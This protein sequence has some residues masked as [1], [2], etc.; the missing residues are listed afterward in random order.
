M[1]GEN[2]GARSGDFVEGWV[3]GAVARATRVF[4]G[5]ICQMF[6]QDVFDGAGA[7]TALHTAAKSAVDLMRG[8]RVRSSSRRQ[9]PYVAIA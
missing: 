1:S 9:V 4:A 6:V 5:A 2:A 3:I 8:Q 7:A